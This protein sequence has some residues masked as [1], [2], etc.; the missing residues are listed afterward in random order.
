MLFLH[1][2]LILGLAGLVA[3]GVDGE[4]GFSI[5]LVVLLMLILLLI[6]PCLM[7]CISSFIM[8]SITA[9]TTRDTYQAMLQIA[10]EHLSDADT[11]TEDDHVQVYE[12]ELEEH[13]ESEPY[14]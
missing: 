7:Q 10:D 9:I 12:F 8:G 13:R 4:L 6:A 14:V 11:Y 3:Y 5:L 1:R 2:G